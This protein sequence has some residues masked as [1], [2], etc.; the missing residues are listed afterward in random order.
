M[1]FMRNHRNTPR[2][3][4]GVAPA[5]L[6]LKRAASYKLPQSRRADPVVEIL[7]KRDVE[8]KWKMKYHADRKI[9]VKHV[10]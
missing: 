9:Y 7:W 4:T 2:S 5:T 10:I 8:Q 6:F 1:A 3:T